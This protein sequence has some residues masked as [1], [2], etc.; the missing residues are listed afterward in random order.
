M[1]RRTAVRVVLLFAA[2]IAAGILAGLVVGTV[3]AYIV[4]PHNDPS[5][6]DGILLMLLWLILAPLG[7][8][9]GCI[10]SV[11]VLTDEKRKLRQSRN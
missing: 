3:I 5:P 10:R 1:T 4:L 6:G 7:A 2:W 9:F 11:V 8:L